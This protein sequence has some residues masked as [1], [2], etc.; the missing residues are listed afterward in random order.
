LY[1]RVDDAFPKLKKVE[2]AADKPFDPKKAPAVTRKHTIDWEHWEAMKD[3]MNKEQIADLFSAPAGDYAPGTDYLTG[4][5]QGGWRRGGHGKVHETLEWRSEKGRIVV[6]FDEQGNY[7]TSEFY[8]PGRD[9]ITNVAERLKWDREKFDKV[10]KYVEERRAGGLAAPAED[11]QG[12]GREP[13]SGTSL[14]QNPTSWAVASTALGV[15]FLGLLTTWWLRR[16]AR[17]G[18]GP[19][20]LHADER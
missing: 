19:R 9:P 17:V 13:L 5:S 2:E 6:E 18:S 8:N 4:G 7:V 20:S 11:G 1:F 16:R 14:L 12:V 3:G 15:L 10:K